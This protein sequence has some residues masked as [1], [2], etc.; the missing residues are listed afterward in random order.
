MS[1]TKY[2]LLLKC[3][4]FTSYL[5]ITLTG[6][7]YYLYNMTLKRCANITGHFITKNIN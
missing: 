2:E 5:T 4:E 3:F 6:M 7:H 1:E